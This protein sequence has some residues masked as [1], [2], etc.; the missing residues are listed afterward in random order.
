LP[1]IQEGGELHSFDTAGNSEAQKKTVEVRLH[2][3]QG[4]VE[5]LSDFLIA[6]TL[7]QQLGNLLFPRREPD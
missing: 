2:R 7:Q 6:A 5:L 4:D 3:A 1:P